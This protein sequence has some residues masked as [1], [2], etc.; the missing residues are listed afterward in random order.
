MADNTVGI[1]RE[2]VENILRMELGM[3]RVFC[4]MGARHLMPDQELTGLTLSQSYLV[5]FEADQAS[6][7]DRFLIQDEY[8]VKVQKT[9]DAVETPWLNPSKEA[10]VLFSAGK[11]MTSVFWDANGIV[12]IY[13]LQ[14]G[15]TID[16]EYFANLLKQFR[17]AIRLNDPVNRQHVSL[18]TSPSQWLLCMK[19]HLAG[20]HYRPDKGVIAAV[21]EFL[22]NQE[23]GFYTTGIQ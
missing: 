17:K 8:W 3:S 22:M 15:R 9:I 10:K 16:R 19:K 5:I 21:E 20:R 23:E 18:P 6:F 11:V 12:F 14:K 1:S 13:Y 4:K 7:L 2:R